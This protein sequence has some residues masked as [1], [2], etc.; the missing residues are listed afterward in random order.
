ML[1]CWDDYS[2]ALNVFLQHQQQ[3][4][5][6]PPDPPNASRL[7]GQ[8]VEDSTV[9]PAPVHALDLV[10]VDCGPSDC[11]V[12]ERLE[13]SMEFVLDRP[14]RGAWWEIKVCVC[15]HTCVCVVGGGG[16]VDVGVAAAVC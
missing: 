11:P 5:N 9:A 13:L 1:G 16:G 6:D 12:D 7:Q 15:V 4:S 14:L 3:C 8:D 10:S 2:S